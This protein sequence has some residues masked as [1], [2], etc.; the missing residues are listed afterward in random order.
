MQTI[1]KLAEYYWCNLVEINMLES[2]ALLWH[3]PCAAPRTVPFY[4]LT[5]PCHQSLASPEAEGA[6]GTSSIVPSC[7]QHSSYSHTSSTFLREREGKG[8]GVKAAS[9]AVLTFLQA[10][11]H[12]VLPDELVGRKGSWMDLQAS[13]QYIL[14]KD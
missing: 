2:L 11:T 10:V 9:G 1:H 6:S 12:D 7:C 3:F 8:R 13:S 4:H 5:Q 14:K